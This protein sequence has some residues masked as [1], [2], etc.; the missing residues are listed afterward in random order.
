[1]NLGNCLSYHRSICYLQRL[2]QN[3]KARFQLLL[4]DDQ[5]RNDQHSMPVR[6]QKQSVIKTMLS[7]R[8]HFRR[9]CIPGRHRLLCL[10]ILYQLDDPEKP[11]GADFTNGGCASPR[12]VNMRFKTG[13]IPAARSTSLSSLITPMFAKAAAREMG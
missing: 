7:Q 5:G 3:L 6:I 10:S 2:I 12:S 1:M 4:G 11:N 9:G 13:P 8:G